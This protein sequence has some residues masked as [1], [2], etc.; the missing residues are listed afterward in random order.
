MFNLKNFICDIKD[1]PN[2]WI[3]EN[4]LE[5]SESLNGQR[6][7]IKSVFN[8]LDK[9]PSMYLYFNTELNTYKF[10]CFSTGKGGTAVELMMYIWN[11]DYKSTISTIMSDYTNYLSD[12]KIHNK[13]DFHTPQWIVSHYVTRQWNS[14][15]AKYWLQY[16]IGSD[17]LNKYNVVP[18][19]SYTMCK[20]IDNKFTDEIFTVKK[21][22]VYGYF[23]NNNELYK[24][25]QPLNLK[26]KF[27]KLGQCIQGVEQLEN[28]KV[29][30]IT[31]SLKDCMAIKSIKKLDV[32][33]I[34]PDSENTKL[35]DKIINK[36]KSEYEA[37]VT[38]MDSDKAGI[39]S[40]LYYYNKFNIPFCYI[41]LS[42]D[43]SDIIKEKGIKEAIT[44]L[45]PVLDKAVAK[46][47]ILNDII[48]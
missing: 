12:G 45:I 7:R 3:F 11:T 16:N 40:M 38:Y 34:A 6:V 32:D 46:Y 4:Y 29:L 24:L 9:D 33:V 1:V 21:Q 17:L 23:N 27:L 39:D 28:K 10:K 44:V 22:N 8:I 48:L 19:E 15:D 5:L 25:Y 13:K 42:K 37:V 26:K 14:N 30:I 31:S 36:Y 47:K 41:P 18:I 43:F 2:D 35:S 20:K